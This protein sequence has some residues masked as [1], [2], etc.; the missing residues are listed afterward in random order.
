VVVSTP[1]SEDAAAGPLRPG[2]D[3]RILLVEDDASLAGVLTLSLGA[4]GYSVTTAALAR[5]AVDLIGSV[6]P[7][8]VILD[9][10]LPDADGVELCRRLRRLSRASIIVVTAD[11]SEERK[12][13]ALDEGADDYVTKP[14]SMPE[15][16]AR[17]RVAVRHS[18]AAR[19]VVDETVVEVGGLRLDSARHRATLEGV[20]LEL[21]PKEFALLALL[22]RHPGKII[23]HRVML[24]RVWGAM[25][26]ERTEYL[27]TYTNQL[28]RKLGQGPTTPRLLTVPAISR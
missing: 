18:R 2:R 17:L 13:A 23:T 11:G 25:S 3:E 15:L 22:A 8:V 6:Q 14:F 20:N 16:L 12:I 21:T 26:A 24:E 27:R 9:L 7:S 5:T 28:R 4:S 19:P 1:L 10:G